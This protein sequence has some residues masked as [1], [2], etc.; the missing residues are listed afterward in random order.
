MFPGY[1]AKLTPG[2]TNVNCVTL[3]VSS[4]TVKV[5]TLP[6]LATCVCAEASLDQ[7]VDS[8]QLESFLIKI[9][10]IEKRY[11]HELKSATSDRRSEVV[12]AVNVFSAKEL[13]RQ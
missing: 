12:E 4:Q 5:A 1:E 2:L 6:P 3:T 13:E 11:A 9:I 7:T 10:T 8:K